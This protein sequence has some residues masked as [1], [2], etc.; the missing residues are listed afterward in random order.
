MPLLS[1]EDLSTHIVL[2]DRTVRAVDGVSFTVEAGETVGLVGESG[3]GKTMTAASITRL[4]PEGGQIVGGRVVLD[5][6]DLTAMREQDMRRIRGRE[7][8]VVFQDPMTS[9]N[10][11]MT[12]GRQV[13][14]PLL[15]HELAEGAAARKR[16]VELL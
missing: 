10:P 4:L 11:T 5:G 16:T 2:P 12:I 1:V 8:G 7:I 13:A 14:E 3:C 9:L 6:R 15:I